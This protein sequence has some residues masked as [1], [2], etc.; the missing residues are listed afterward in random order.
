MHFGGILHNSDV[1]LDF[2]DFSIL[3]NVLVCIGEIGNLDGPEP[4]SAL[5]SAQIAVWSKHELNGAENR[6]KHTHGR[7]EVPK[8]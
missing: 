2:E 4:L 5:T 3:R 6:Q 7:S 8:T 1:V